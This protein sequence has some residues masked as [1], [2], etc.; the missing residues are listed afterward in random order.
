MKISTYAAYRNI[1]VSWHIVAL[2]SETIHV[3]VDWGN[4]LAEIYR[5]S[6]DGVPEYAVAP[7]VSR[8]QKRR[9]VAYVIRK[10]LKEVE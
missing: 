10:H 9:R 2:G 8:H 4:N 5:D 1:D 6:L 7:A 3:R